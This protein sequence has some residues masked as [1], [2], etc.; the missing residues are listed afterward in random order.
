[1]L[2]LTDAAR[3]SITTFLDSPAAAANTDTGL[4]Y[5]HDAAES[6]AAAESALQDGFAPIA[7]A[8]AIAADLPPALQAYVPAA[9]IA[10]AA[11]LPAALYC[12]QAAADLLN[13]AAA[14][15]DDLPA[16]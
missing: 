2:I 10:A 4:H 6:A 7:A 5:L 14:F 12:V 9:M 16:A 8:D 15:S 3:E 11:D 13:A 1:M